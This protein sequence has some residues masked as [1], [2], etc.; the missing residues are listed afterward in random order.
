[1]SF[2]N[3][4]I[5]LLLLIPGILF[6]QERGCDLMI[7]PSTGEI[8]GH[9]NASNIG[10]GD[11]ICLKPGLRSYLWIKYLHGTKEHPIVIQNVT[12]G[13]D[14]TDFYY[15]IKIDSCSYIKLSGKGVPSL[16]YGIRIHDIAGGGLSIENLSTDVEIEG[17]EIGYTVLAGIF[18]KSDPNCQFNST[19]DKYVLHN[20]SIHDN[21]IH[22]TGM[23]GFYI[24]SSFYSGKTINCDGKDTLVYP[25]VLK[26]VK[27]FNNIVEY[28]GWDGIQVASADSGCFIYNNTVKY[29]SD[30]AIYNQMSGI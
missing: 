26:G 28:A 7:N 25:H 27:V 1:M 19:R 18:A 17:L 5:F 24:G 11:T 9:G 3:Y 30:S 15:G 6:S 22:H 13:V 16:N 4:L 20:L 23:E 12:G 2:V 29:D 8:D 21:Y 14:I 10:P